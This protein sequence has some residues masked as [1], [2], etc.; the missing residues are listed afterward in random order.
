MCDVVQCDPLSKKI[1]IVVGRFA[2]REMTKKVPHQQ[3]PV[4]ERIALDRNGAAKTTAAEIIPRDRKALAEAARAGKKIDYRIGIDGVITLTRDC[5]QFGIPEFPGRLETVPAQHCYWRNRRQ[6]ACTLTAFAR[7]V[8]LRNPL[9][10]IGRISAHRVALSQQRGSLFSLF[11][12]PPTFYIPQ[13][14]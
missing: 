6:S 5:L 3:R 11:R 13:L 14:R 2:C 9:N 8:L 1:V 4:R 12:D 10:K 7:R